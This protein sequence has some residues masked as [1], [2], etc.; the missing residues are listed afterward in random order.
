MCVAEFHEPNKATGRRGFVKLGAAA[1]ASAALAS[2]LEARRAEAASQGA[3]IGRINVDNIVDLTH[4][5]GPDTPLLYALLPKFALVN[6]VTHEKD[7]FYAGQ[8]V[9]GEHSGTHFDAPIHFA[10]DALYTHEIPASTLVAPAVVVD[11]SAKAAADPDAALTVDDLRAW[12]AGHGRIPD[13]AAVLLH[14]GWASRINDVNAMRNIGPDKLM[15][16]PG[17]SVE[18]AQFLLAE[19]NVVGIGTDALSTDLGTSEN[20]E[21]HRIV[22]PANKWMLESVANLDSI[23]PAGAH[24]F[25]GAPKHVRG[26]GGPVRL[27]AVW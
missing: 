4:A 5:L 2:R 1:V 17:Y 24:L 3:P 26:S 27:I 8:I 13:G 16:F 22:S 14:S 9:V 19:R 7:G 25:V 15:H 10:K 6:F 23:P 20:F 21:V 11:I 12:E 18:A